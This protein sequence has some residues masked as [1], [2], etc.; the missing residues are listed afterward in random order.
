MIPF[1]FVDDR[2]G[3]SWAIV[4]RSAT[5]TRGHQCRRGGR[6]EPFDPARHLSPV[7]P[8]GPG[9]LGSLRTIWLPTSIRDGDSLVVFIA[10]PD[11]L[12]LSRHENLFTPLDQLA[13]S[14]RAER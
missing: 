6:L 12:V 8:P 5:A 13:I 9:L 14:I 7:E 1:D 10:T 3:L 11:G 4:R 2:D